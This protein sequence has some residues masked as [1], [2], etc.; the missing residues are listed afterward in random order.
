M[1]NRVILRMTLFLIA[2]LL[3]STCGK[4]P[5][6][7]AQD[8]Y[9]GTQ[10]V[11]IIIGTSGPSL[12]LQ[13]FKYMYGV[14]YSRS[15]STW[16][17]TATDATIDSTSPDKRS[18]RVLFNTLPANDTALIKVTETTSAGVS[19]AEKVLKV[20]VKAFCPLAVSGFVGTWTGTDGQGPDYIYS[21]TMTTTLSGTK[22]LVHGINVG[23]MGDFWGESII[24]GGTCLMTVNNDGTVTIP[25]QFFC[26]TDYSTGY[27][28]KGSGTWDNCGAKPK[29]IINYDIW[30]LD[31]TRWL[32][33]Y[34]KSYFGGKDYLTATLTKN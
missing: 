16:D 12:G 27:K 24:T 7:K 26:D 25:E 15:G 10:V 6:E 20:K 30:W 8:A 17:W 5:M 32:A 19:S 33:V 1:K 23:W 4:L 14:T 22:I 3:F 29:L 31:K 13:T 9:D 21:T 34:Y 28:I 11:P 18:V 2:V